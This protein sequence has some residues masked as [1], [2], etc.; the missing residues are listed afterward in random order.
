MFVVTYNTDCGDGTSTRNDA[1]FRDRDNAL[2]YIGEQVRTLRGSLCE[3]PP[4]DADDD[5]TWKLNDY[6]W[7]E[8]EELEVRD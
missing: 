6:A 8:I 3:L 4:F 7:F 1:L 2:S 5:S